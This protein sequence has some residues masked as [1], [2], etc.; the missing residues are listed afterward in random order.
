[1]PTARPES[2]G[3][4]KPSGPRSRKGVETRARLVAAAKE[5]FERDGFLDA[6]ISDIAEKA[7]L[8]HGSFYHYFESKEEV[9]REV[10]AEVDERLSAPMTNIILDPNSP[11]SPFDRIQEAMRIHLEAYRDEGRIMGV[12]EQ[13]SRFDPEVA[14]TRFERQ[15]IGLNEVAHSIRSLQRRGL[16]DQRLD[17]TITAAALGAMTRR[18]PE[19]WLVEHVIDDDFDDVLE[20]FT[21]IFA[22]AL[23]LD[24]SERDLPRASATRPTPSAQ[25]K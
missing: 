14:T 3:N 1:M 5:I 19:A 13:V 4:D 23:G 20:Q 6:R 2:N 8:S 12:I 11:L 25:T 16:I 15:L 18:F 24:V 21:F 22:R 17:P 10:V 7:G 9:F